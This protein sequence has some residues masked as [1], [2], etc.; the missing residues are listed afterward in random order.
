MTFLSLS[1]F[2]FHFFC[3]L[4]IV[5]SYVDLKCSINF[6]CLSLNCLHRSLY[7]SLMRYVNTFE[8]FFITFSNSRLIFLAVTK[9]FFFMTTSNSFLNCN[10]SGESYFIYWCSS[11]FK[12]L[13]Y[14]SYCSDNFSV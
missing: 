7:L 6:C 5:D 10:C 3:T 9:S 14:F 13:R 4:T 11:S 8:S 2:L 12:S 1:S